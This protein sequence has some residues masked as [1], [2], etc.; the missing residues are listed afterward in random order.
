[1]AVKR[2]R[3]QEHEL[4]HQLWVLISAEPLIQGFPGLFIAPLP[5]EC[6]LLADRVS[7]LT[8]HQ[9]VFSPDYTHH[10]YTIYMPHTTTP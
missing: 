7:L 5:A 6:V 2:S 10:P 1:M 8:A 4:Q 3:G 9:P